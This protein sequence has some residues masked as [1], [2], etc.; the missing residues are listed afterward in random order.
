MK[1]DDRAAINA[2]DRDPD[3]GM[4][5]EH[6]NVKMIKFKA[7]DRFQKITTIDSH[8][9]GEPFRIITGGVPDPVGSTILEKRRYA[10][11]NLDHI[12]KMLMFEP[13]GHA[14]MYGC[15]VTPPV[16]PLADFGVL[17]IHNEGFSTMCGHGIIALTTVAVE[18]GFA[19]VSEEKPHIMIDSPAGLITA[20]PYIENGRVVSVTFENVAS[21]APELDQTIDIPGLG[22]VRYDLALAVRFMPL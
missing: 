1:P 14:D 17:F 21:F 8:T 15:F 13:R 20:Y 6:R 16:T 10:K 12:R 19:K 18:T 3:P 5:K 4:H 11:Q 2:T 22:Q 9:A 7:P